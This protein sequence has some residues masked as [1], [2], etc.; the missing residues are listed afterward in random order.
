M[1][2]IEKEKKGEEI[3]KEEKI[4]LKGNN[5]LLDKID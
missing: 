4:E 3:K 1:E 5:E 2:N